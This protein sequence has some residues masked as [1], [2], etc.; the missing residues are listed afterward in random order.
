MKILLV[1]MSV[2]CVRY[3]ECRF[4]PHSSC[5]VADSIQQHNSLKSWWWSPYR[6]RPTVMHTPRVSSYGQQWL[7]FQMQHSTNNI[8]EIAHMTNDGYC[9]FLVHQKS[10][11]NFTSKMPCKP[12]QNGEIGYFG[13]SFDF[14]TN[15]RQITIG[16]GD[17][18]T[19]DN[20]FLGK[21]GK[22]S[23]TTSIRNK[24]MAWWNI[25]FSQQQRCPI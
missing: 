7:I 13:T 21:R 24:H 4:I 3:A 25:N 9:R 14:L 18:A 20:L 6:S 19:S 5:F 2:L 23:Y 1:A 12:N 10:A 8:I 17:V 15:R 22:S 16:S 11:P